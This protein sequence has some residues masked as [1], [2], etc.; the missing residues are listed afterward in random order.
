ATEIER[1]RLLRCAW[2]TI[3]ARRRRQMAELLL[4]PDIS[5]TSFDP[6]ARDGALPDRARTVVVGAGVAGSSVAYH[7]ALLGE[8]DV[9]LLDRMSVASGTS[10]HAAGNVVRTRA[11]QSLSAFAAYGIDLYARLGAET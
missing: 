7:L 11:N 6:K 2:G 10:W 5:A 1:A 4:E 9:L 3:G 8:R